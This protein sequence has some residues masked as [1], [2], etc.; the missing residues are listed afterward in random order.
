M[1]VGKD[2]VVAE[3]ANYSGR[4]LVGCFCSKVGVEALR[5]WIDINQQPILRYSFETHTLVRGWSCFIFKSE[6]DCV[7]ILSFS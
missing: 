7:T 3:V 6:E 5:R 4:T 2:I 1:V